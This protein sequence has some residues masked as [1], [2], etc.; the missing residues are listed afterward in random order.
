MIVNYILEK[1]MIGCT[2][3]KLDVCY[4]CCYKIKQMCKNKELLKDQEAEK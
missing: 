2:G 1:I 4:A 3:D